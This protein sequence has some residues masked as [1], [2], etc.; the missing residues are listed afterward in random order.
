M[1]IVGNFLD[2]A[3]WLNWLA[4]KIQSVGDF[5]FFRQI[6]AYLQ[7]EIH[8]FG[9]DLLGRAMQWVSGI[10]LTLLTLWIM[11]QGYRIVTG[12]S[13]ES[14]MALVTNSLRSVLILTAATMMAMFGTDLHQFLN[15]DV[16]KEIN[17]VVTGENTTPE[18]KI[19]ENLAWMQVALSSIDALDVMSDPTLDNQKSRAMWFAGVG[20]GGPA[21]VGG[22][23]LLL[24]E[25]A[26]ALFVGFGPIFILCLMFD[27]TKSLFQRWL[28]YGIGTM[29]SMAVLSAMVSIALEM[30][31]RV[32]AAFWGTALV[33]SLLGSNFSDGM[34]SQAM[35]Q[36]GMGMILTLLIVSV[37]PM[38]AAFFQGTLGNF[39]HFSAFSGGGAPVGQRAGESGYRGGYGSHRAANTEIE[40]VDSQIPS[41]GGG[42]TFNA[43]R[44]SGSQPATAQ[45]P[46]GQR[47]LANNG[48]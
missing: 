18:D 21:I 39:M 48:T 9:I 41:S 45:A 31:V 29:F 26:M 40:R 28:L 16:K 22:T 7:N 34:T 47:G 37:P 2:G 46:S 15:D 32:S 17:W 1:D 35:Q 5:I 11:I 25:V 44:V 13:R 30:V 42:P 12:Q 4:P 10:A 3:G 14:M 36:G 8:E 38:A 33:G 43:G 23:L 27:Q 24:Y 20:A 19:D 6:M